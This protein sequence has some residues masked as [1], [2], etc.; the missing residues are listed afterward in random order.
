MMLENFDFI[1]LFVLCITTPPTTKG[2][3]CMQCAGVSSPEDCLTKVTCP[4]QYQCF[5]DFY[6][7]EQGFL[8]YDLGCRINQICQVLNGQH[9]R[10]QFLEKRQFE[11]I[12]LCEECCTTDFCNRQGCPENS[13]TRVNN[14]LCFNCQDASSPEKCDTV[15]VCNYDEICIAA[16][17]LTE[18]FQERYQLRCEKKHICD[19][20]VGGQFYGQPSRI[21]PPALGRRQIQFPLTECQYCCDSSFC[22]NKACVK[23]TTPPSHFETTSIFTVQ[24]SCPVDWAEYKGECLYFGNSRQRWLDAENHC[25]KFHAYLVTDDNADKH[26][27]ISNVISVLHSLHQNTFWIGANDFA[28]EGSFRW[29]ETGL[30]IG[31]FSAWGSGRPT[32]NDTNNCLRMFYNGD[33]YKWEDVS[34]NDRTTY[35]ICEKPAEQSGTP[36]Y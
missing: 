32:R 23:G 2:L 34:C 21:P 24:T 15:D 19:R 16:L 3:Q 7:T 33:Q 26:N 14:T 28:I 13:V 20:S 4:D 5:T 25:R 30:P 8:Y 36:V 29:L 12:H 18:L 6:V 9:L 35:F 17:V 10:T 11:N 31:N 27:F 22:N 1:L